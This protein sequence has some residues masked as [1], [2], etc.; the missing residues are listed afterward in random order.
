MNNILAQRHEILR[1][2]EEMAREQS[3]GE[4]GIFTEN[5]IDI[6]DRWVN[7]FNWHLPHEGFT[8]RDVIN[9]R[10]WCFDNDLRGDNIELANLDL[11][12]INTQNAPRSRRRPR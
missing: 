12:K 1:T 6:I 5:H 4:I 10:K 3:D 11:Y 9:F 2:G 8:I 7:D